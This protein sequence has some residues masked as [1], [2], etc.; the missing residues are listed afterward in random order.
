M[1]AL[2]FVAVLSLGVSA[3]RAFVT[4]RGG[5]TVNIFDT[6]TNTAL[7]GNPVT[8]GSGPIDIAADRPPSTSAQELFVANSGSNSVSVVWSNPPGVVATLSSDSFFGTFATPSGVA[9][10]DDG[11]IGPTI[12]M[13]DQKSTSYIYGASTFSGRS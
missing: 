13:V 4:N 5:S 1:G 9:L 6:A 3:D 12:A 11:V 8:V 2:L 7:A 10:A